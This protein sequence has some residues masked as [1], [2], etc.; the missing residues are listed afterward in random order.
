VR[1][2]QCKS[3]GF[4]MIGDMGARVLNCNGMGFSLMV[5]MLQLGVVLAIGGRVDRLVDRRIDRY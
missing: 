4:S 5:Q 3:R 1:G 2:K